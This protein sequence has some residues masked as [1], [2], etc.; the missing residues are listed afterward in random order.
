M[1]RNL[2]FRNAWKL[3]SES[4]RIFL[5]THEG[6]DG[7]DLGSLLAIFQLLKQLGKEPVAGVKGGVP[8]NLEFLPFSFE[9]TDGF[10]P[11]SY[12]LV[13]TFGCSNIL[14]PN[15]P[16]LEK[17]NLPVINFDHHPDN[18][19]FGTV[20]VVDPETAAVAEL[21]YHFLKHQ[22]IEVNKDMAVC[23]LTGIFTDTGGFKHANTSASALNTA[24]ELVKKGAR[25][26]HISIQVMGHRRPESLKIW[27]RGLENT[28]FDSQKKLLFSVLS[29]EDIKEM[30]AHAEDLDGFVEFLN[31][32]PEARFVLVLRQ[33][34]EIIRGNLRSDINKGVDVSKIAKAFGGGGHKLASGFKLK[35]RLVKEKNTW[36]I[37]P[38]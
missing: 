16:E 35:G 22:K 38:A 23:M 3:I 13:I 14:R 25:I 7:D 34:G 36:R 30:N 4:S 6:T 24:G 29:E 9:V 2:E 12:D 15:L 27:A 37:V 11:G 28:R 33:D 18:T 20:N 31:N 21:I 19:N 17:L 1:N 8:K 10:V 5:T 26:D 32:I